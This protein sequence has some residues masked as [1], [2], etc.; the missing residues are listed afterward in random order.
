MAKLIASECFEA[1]MEE[2]SK[3]VK[4]IL[5]NPPDKMDREAFVA[6]YN[7]LMD[8]AEQVFDYLPEGER[9]DI[10]TLCATWMDIGILLGRSPQLL[11]DILKRTGAKIEEATNAE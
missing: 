7:T 8:M 2:V 9:A 11:T 10:K 1:V 3:E 4:K 5:D 6:Y